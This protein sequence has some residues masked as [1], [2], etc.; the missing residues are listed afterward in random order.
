MEDFREQG[1]IWAPYIL[2]VVSTSVNGETVW[3]SNRWKN[4]LLKIKRLF[5]KPKYLKMLGK[6]G[7]KEI[8]PKIYG[9]IKINNN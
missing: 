7:K 9:E 3:Y 4:F 5:F 8:N 2:K 6:Y 1:Y